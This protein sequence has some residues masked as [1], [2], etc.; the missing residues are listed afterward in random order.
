MRRAGQ[1]GRVAA[2]ENCPKSVSNTTE[3]QEN[4]K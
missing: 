3:A 1:Q 2:A 4:L